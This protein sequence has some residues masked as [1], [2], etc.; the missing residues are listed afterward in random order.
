[1]TIAQREPQ[2]AGAV[3]LEA[4]QQFPDGG[5]PVCRLLT[6]RGDQVLQL[7]RAGCVGERGGGPERR[8]VGRAVQDHA[9]HVRAGAEQ[10]GPRGLDVGEAVAERATIQGAALPIQRDQL[11]HGHRW[12]GW[13]RHRN[14][15]A[16]RFLL[17]SC[18]LGA[19]TR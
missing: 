5:Q 2:V 14:A 4:F 10:R 17:A 16:E 1:V 9:Q 7:P 3:G 13:M 18:S 6:T 11:L 8:A 15:H 19:Y 12:V